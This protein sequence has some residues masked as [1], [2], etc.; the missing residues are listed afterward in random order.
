MTQKELEAA[1]N[2]IVKQ[3]DDINLLY[4]K[5][6]AAQIKK[7]G[8]LS[9]SSVN[10]L[11]AMAEMNADIAEINHKLQ[12]AAGVTSAELTQLYKDV[13]QDTYTDNAF[14]RFYPHTLYRTKRKHA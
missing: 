3:L 13:L 1:I 12:T 4:I 8:E 14:P 11:L 10:R 9:Q 6:V 5:K 7:I 2:R